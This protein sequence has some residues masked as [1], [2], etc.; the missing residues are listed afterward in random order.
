MR[1]DADL[2][3]GGLALLGLLARSA[4]VRRSALGSMAKRPIPDDL[5]AGWFRP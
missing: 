1:P 2:S 4:R 5:L 3:I